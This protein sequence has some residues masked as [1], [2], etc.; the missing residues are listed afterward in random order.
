MLLKG[1]TGTSWEE[2]ELEVTLR[3]VSAS[4]SIQICEDY[5]VLVVVPS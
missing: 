1:L 4:Y 5:S 2:A 3:F